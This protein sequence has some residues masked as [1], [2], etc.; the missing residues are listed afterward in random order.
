MP[1]YAFVENGIVKNVVLADES[2]AAANGLVECGDVG[3]GWS[4]VDGV[5]S[6]PP[7]DLD[8]MA[9][10]VRAQRDMLLAATDWRVIRATETN[11]PLSTEWEAYRQAL[12]DIT[13]Q[14]GF[15][16]TVTWPTEPA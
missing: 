9:R 6:P 10:D 11:T 2:F 3:P 14:P 7:P 4:Y 16:Q 8:A 1:N 12:R 5:F 13:L 15:P